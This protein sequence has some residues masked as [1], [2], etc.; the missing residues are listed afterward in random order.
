MQFNRRRAQL[1]QDFVVSLGWHHVS[2][3]AEQLLLAL[4]R[5]W[6]GRQR[7]RIR[8]ERHRLEGPAA[9]SK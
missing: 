8:C 1:T 7:S 9:Q 2:D 3:E 4:Q 5:R 6:L